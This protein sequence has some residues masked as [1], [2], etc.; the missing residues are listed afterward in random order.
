MN[1]SLL[2]K[3]FLIGVVTI[4]TLYTLTTFVVDKT[5]YAIKIR[6]GDPI[7]QYK[8]P[9]LKFKLP[10]VTK[11]FFVDNRLLTYDADPGSIITKDKKEMIVDN[12]SK[13]KVVD[14]LK[15]YETVR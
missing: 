8:T 6:L 3:G 2:I 9:G 4:V 5:Q 10:F 12:Y 15:F 1:A 14:P 13:W 11:V 7:T